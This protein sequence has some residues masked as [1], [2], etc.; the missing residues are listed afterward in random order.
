MKIR[1]SRNA[2]HYLLL[3]NLKLSDP[4]KALRMHP[5]TIFNEMPTFSRLPNARLVFFA[6]NYCVRPQPDANSMVVGAGEHK[7]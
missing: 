3:Q 6:M 7:V 1:V 4:R 2:N 5:Q